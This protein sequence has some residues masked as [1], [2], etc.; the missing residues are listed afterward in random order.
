M[1]AIIIDD[2]DAR[3]LIA[4][5]ELERLRKNHPT[6]FAPEKTPT[7]DDMHRLFHYVV[8]RWLQDQG[9]NTIR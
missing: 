3:E 5:L 1:R 4:S 7:H 6:L 8:V 9:C 2:K